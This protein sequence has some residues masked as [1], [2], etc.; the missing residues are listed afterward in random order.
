MFGNIKYWKKI[1]NQPVDAIYASIQNTFLSKRTNRFE[2][3]LGDVYFLKNLT[4][5]HGTSKE[6]YILVVCFEFKIITNETFET[7]QIVKDNRI[8]IRD[9]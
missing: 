9:Y 5:F 4:S 1:K 2:M 7:S 3:S 8:I 6:V